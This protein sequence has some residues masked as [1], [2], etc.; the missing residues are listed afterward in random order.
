M[1]SEIEQAKAAVDAE[2]R[3]VGVQ[4]DELLNWQAHVDPRNAGGCVAVGFSVDVALPILR[5]LPDQAG[6]S[7]FLAAIRDH[8]VEFNG[9]RLESE[10][11]AT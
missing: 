6:T 10:D 2:L 7:A 4:L 5:A 1:D 9:R 11:E 8:L 3:R